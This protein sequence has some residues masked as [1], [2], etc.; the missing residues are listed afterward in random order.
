LLANHYHFILKQLVDNGIE[1]FMHKLGTGYTNYFN[2][3]HK[4]TGALFEGPFKA[5]PINNDGKLCQLSAYVNCNYEIHKLGKAEYWKFCSYKDYLRLR[6]GK[7]INKDVVLELF[8]NN[9]DEYIKYCGIVIKES[10]DKK[11]VEKMLVE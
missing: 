9:I 3:K 2:T 8:N 4:R 5:Y 7:L 1:T 6:D 11:R 10:Q